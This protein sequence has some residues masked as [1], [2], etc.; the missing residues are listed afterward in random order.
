MRRWSVEHSAPHKNLDPYILP[1]PSPNNYVNNEMPVLG[2]RIHPWR[3]IVGRKTKTVVVISSSRSA[4]AWSKRP[5]LLQ[6]PILCLPR[7]SSQEALS[8]P[9]R[10]EITKYNKHVS[11]WD[12]G[13]VKIL[14][15]MQTTDFWYTHVISIYVTHQTHLICCFWAVGAVASDTTVSHYRQLTILTAPLVLTHD[16]YST[17]Y[18]TL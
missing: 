4:Q 17:Y 6:W 12:S 9:T 13:R 1:V 15:F 2:A 18:N 3:L 10:I 7:T 8:E 16:G 5:L 14:W 11:F